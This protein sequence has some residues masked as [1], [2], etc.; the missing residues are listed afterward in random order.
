MA[1]II[2]N[3]AL[4]F[5]HQIELIPN[6]L[7]NALYHTFI[8]YFV[9][10]LM[11]LIIYFPRATFCGFYQSYNYLNII[12]FLSNLKKQTIYNWNEYEYEMEQI[13]DLDFYD[14]YKVKI[15]TNDGLLFVIENDIKYFI[16]F[17]EC[18]LLVSE[19]SKVYLNFSW[20]PSNHIL[21]D[22]SNGLVLNRLNENKLPDLSNLFRSDM[23]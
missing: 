11:A 14:I 6:G 18:Y 9:I 3:N 5:P 10:V 16:D 19:I 22:T 23:G 7:L 21:I 12:Y 4:L 8:S 17:P 2:D 1:D 15:F 20:V 13:F